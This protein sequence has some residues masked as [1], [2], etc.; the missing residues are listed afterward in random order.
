MSQVEKRGR[1]A[2]AILFLIFTI[3]VLR[4]EKL[5]TNSYMMASVAATWGVWLAT[6]FRR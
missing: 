6:G 4:E 3:L 2:A 1:I 5:V